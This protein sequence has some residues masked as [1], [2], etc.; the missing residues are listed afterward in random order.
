MLF[1]EAWLHLHILQN[2]Y[3]MVELR[4]SIREKENKIRELTACEASY[5]KLQQLEENGRMLGLVE[6]QLHQIEVVRMQAPSHTPAQEPD[7]AAIE[8]ARLPKETALTPLAPRG[9]D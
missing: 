8:F 9:K 5:G 4:S 3:Q 6:P 2:G 1:A 7:P